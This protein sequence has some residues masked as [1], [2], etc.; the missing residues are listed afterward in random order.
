MPQLSLAQCLTLACTLE[1]TAPKVGNVHRG[2]DFDDVSLNDFL[3]SAVAIGPIL[4]ETGTLGVGKAI[5]Q[6]VQATREFVGS[7]TNLGMILLLAPLAAV[8]RATPLETGIAEVLSKL[9]PQDANAVYQAIALAHPGGLGRAEEMD[10]HDAPP[11]SLVE[12]MTLAAERDLV[13]KQ[14]ASQF[15]EVLHE[16]VP[17]LTA[18]QWSLPDTIVHTH[19][20]LLAQHGD[21]LIAR[22]GGGAE[23]QAARD[24]AATVLAAGAPGDENYGE[25]LAD[26]DFWL[27]SAGR[28]RNP[29][30][31]AD[32]IAAG[33]FAALR[34][35]RLGP[36]WR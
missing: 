28:R 3:V 32:L 13:A 24:R 16:V 36:P 12:A 4:A 18:G 20:Q 8:P 29:G 19:L 25:A 14:Y 10:I 11:T 33:L 34:A 5:L 22:K 21:S 15:H 30:T 23:S 35:G 6:A 17:A 1:V 9:T 26:F 7:N 27:R 31:T 2:A